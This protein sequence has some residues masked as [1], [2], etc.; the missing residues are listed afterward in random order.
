M[1]PPPPP[2]GRSQSLRR[3]AIS[4]KTQEGGCRVPIS[5]LRQTPTNLDEDGRPKPTAQP[6]TPNALHR[7]ASSRIPGSAT[8]TSQQPG[9]I[10]SLHSRTQSVTTVPS[11]QTTA[12]RLTRS[13]TITAAHARSKSSVI[14]EPVKSAQSSPTT[15][16]APPLSGQDALRKRSGTVGRD[17][18]G[19]S[20]LFSARARPTFNTLQQHYSP[21][22]QLAPR[23]PIPSSRS[24]PG[25]VQQTSAGGAAS[26][27]EMTKLQ[28]ELLYLSLLH[29]NADS[30]LRAYNR[31]AEEAL[32]TKYTALQNEQAQSK[33]T[34]R[35]HRQTINTNA[36][37]EWAGYTGNGKTGL[38]QHFGELIRRLSSCLHELVGLSGTEGR[39]SRLVEDFSA[40]LPAMNEDAQS[41]G[42]HNA[43]YAHQVFIDA[44]PQDWHDSHASISQRLRLLERDIEGLPPLP[45]C[46][47]ESGVAESAL[48]KF[49]V[50]LTS[51]TK[52]MRTELDSMFEIQK[53]V[54]EREAER[55]ENAI[56]KIQL[57]ALRD[58]LVQAAA[59]HS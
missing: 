30:T 3:P 31:S 4:I 46:S 5:P 58:G 14:G 55:V 39:Y 10:R 41:H 1:L 33:E 21:A 29:Q 26:S 48:A 49:L 50:V 47:S 45:E 24:E 43:N 52:G 35:L 23:P 6:A 40:W 2:L 36:L 17:V 34:E 13:A 56:S 19:S 28:S 32:R 54:R 27:F 53:M 42:L 22:K 51:M 9:S 7:S 59:W 16:K 44:L 15:G 37:A 11:T 57:G 8:S 18:S 20:T 38:N 25:V 12:S